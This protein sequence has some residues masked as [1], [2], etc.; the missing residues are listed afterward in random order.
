MWNPIIARIVDFNSRNGRL[1]KN[2]VNVQGAEMV[3]LYLLF[4]GLYLN[5]IKYDSSHVN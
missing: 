4:S 5:M 1:L 2:Q 3:E